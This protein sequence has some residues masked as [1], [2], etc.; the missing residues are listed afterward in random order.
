[1]VSAVLVIDEVDLVDLGRA[2]PVVLVGHQVGV[3]RHS[4]VLG[5]LE[6]AAAD[7]RRRCR[8]SLAA[9]SPGTVAQMCCGTMET[10]MSSMLALGLVQVN[11]TVLSLGATTLLMKFVY[12]V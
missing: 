6:G 12:I 7:D 11:T 9:W 3:A 10:H 5:E 4:L 1:M 2:A 8:R